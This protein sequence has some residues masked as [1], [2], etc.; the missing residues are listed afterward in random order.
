MDK[1][2]ALTEAREKFSEIVNAV[3]Y[4]GDTYIISKSGKPAVAVVPLNIL[5]Q[6]QRAREK[7][8]AIIDEIQ[9]QNSDS[10]I[11][12]WDEETL[13]E[14]LADLVYEGRTSA[15]KADNAA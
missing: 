6:W 11:L 4:H 13:M 5:E 10:E 15:K 3:M 9:A 8:F 14:T 2:I 12:Q 1:Q 7:Q